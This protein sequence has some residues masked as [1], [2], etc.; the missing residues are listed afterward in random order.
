VRAPAQLLVAW[1]GKLSPSVWPEVDDYHK[2]RS[3]RNLAKEYGISY[4]AVRRTISVAQMVKSNQPLDDPKP[5]ESSMLSCTDLTGI[6][7]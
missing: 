2:A 5:T 3:L 7:R 4:E 6:E 1:R